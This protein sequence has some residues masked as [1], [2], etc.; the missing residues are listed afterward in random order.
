MDRNIVPERGEISES[1]LNPPSTA[2]VILESK[3]TAESANGLIPSDGLEFKGDDLPLSKYLLG[4][5]FKDLN[6]RLKLIHL[7]SQEERKKVGFWSLYTCFDDW[8]QV[9]N[10]IDLADNVE[11]LENLLQNYGLRIKSYQTVAEADKTDAFQLA[12]TTDFTENRRPIKD[13][14]DYIQKMASYKNKLVPVEHNILNFLQYL[15]DN[16]GVEKAESS[17]IELM[18]LKMNGHQVDSCFIF[19]LGYN[20]QIKAESSSAVEEPSSNYLDLVYKYLLSICGLNFFLYVLR[21]YRKQNKKLI[22]K[23]DKAKQTEEDLKSQL[24]NLKN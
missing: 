20:D 19:Q 5:A 10:F 7:M 21:R 8:G 13:F 16:Y 23:V 18:N 3:E 12:T 1:K 22:V 2:L 17:F 6:V 9:L 14:T 15:I 4:V 11:A 24:K